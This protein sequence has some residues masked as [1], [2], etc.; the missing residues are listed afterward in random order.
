MLNKMENKEIIEGFIGI[1]PYTNGKD[2]NMGLIFKKTIMKDGKIFYICPKVVL[3]LDE[4]QMQSELNK[5]FV[6]HYNDEK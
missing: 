5:G 4:E 6:E 2:G 1:K 3:M